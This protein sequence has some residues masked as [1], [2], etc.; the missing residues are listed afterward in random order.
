MSYDVLLITPNLSDGGT[1]RVVTHLANGWCERGVKVG[2]LTLSDKP[3]AYHL[4][5]EVDRLTFISRVSKNAINRVRRVHPVGQFL[6][7]RLSA[8]V[9]LLSLYLDFMWPFL[10]KFLPQLAEVLRL[11][12]RLEE[13]ETDLVV[14]FLGATNMQTILACRSLDCRVV[15]SERN[16]PAIQHLNPPWQYLRPHLYNE[17]DLVTANTMGALESMR[18]YV[19]GNKLAFVPN[20]LPQPPKVDSIKLGGPF[21]LIVGRLHAQ[22]AHDVLLEAFALMTEAL[23]DWRLVVVGQGDLESKLRALSHSL[24]LTEKVLWC[25]QVDD[26]YPYY[27][28]AS[29]FVLP[30]R[31]EG[32]PN[33]LMEALNC[34]LPAIVSDASPG[35]LALIE[36]GVNGIVVPVEDA[37]SLASAMKRLANETALRARMSRAACE[38]VAEYGLANALEVWEGH[39]GL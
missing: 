25:G 2:V 34:G 30:S 10:A 29:A 4:N 8:H 33:A 5:S 3:D 28:G 38:S 37:E 11:R 35:P 27:L 15:I 31:H 20:P 7:D 6:I 26:P 16:D 12:A 36:D 23:P 18:S 21:F 39:L 9:Y 14:S 22:K 1:Q 32:M 24:G 19:D 13:L 17:A